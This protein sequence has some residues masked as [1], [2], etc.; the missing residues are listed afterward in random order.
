MF[1]ILLVMGLELF[2]S[3][4]CL[5]L[6]IPALCNHNYGMQNGVVA[7]PHPSFF[8]SCQAR[9]RCF[10]AFAYEQFFF[11]LHEASLGI[12]SAVLRSPGLYTQNRR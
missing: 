2:H 11:V 4:N 1:Y 7:S 8:C 9:V 12:G 10:M 6:S 3:D 5:E